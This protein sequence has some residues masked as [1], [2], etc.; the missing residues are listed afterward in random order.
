MALDSQETTKTRRSMGRAEAVRTAPSPGTRTSR[1]QA[2]RATLIPQKRSCFAVRT[3]VPP[4]EGHPTEGRAPASPQSL[5]GSSLPSFSRHLDKVPAAPL[6]VRIAPTLGTR[7]SR[8]QAVQTT[9]VSQRR[10]QIAVRRTAGPFPHCPLMIFPLASAGEF[11][12]SDLDHGRD[13]AVGCLGTGF[14]RVRDGS[15]FPGD[16]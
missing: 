2:V 11:P 12:A 6:T 14:W 9:P 1:P 16:S 15:T 7:T 5:R 8:P 4:K 13:L 3:Q 10:S